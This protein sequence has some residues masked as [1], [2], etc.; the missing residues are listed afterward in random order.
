MLPV[1][2]VTGTRDVGTDPMPT[3]MQCVALPAPSETARSVSLVAVIGD[4]LP[5]LDSVFAQTPN[6]Y[7]VQRGWLEPSCPILREMSNWG[8]VSSH[9]PNITWLHWGEPTAATNRSR[10]REL[11]CTRVKGVMKRVKRDGGTMVW[12]SE[13]KHWPQLRN[14]PLVNSCPVYTC[15]LGVDRCMCFQVSIFW[16]HL[17]AVP[18]VCGR[19][20]AGEPLAPPER[21]EAYAAFCNHVF[22]WIQNQSHSFPATGTEGPSSIPKD[23]GASPSLGMLGATMDSTPAPVGAGVAI[24]PVGLTLDPNRETL[25]SNNHKR[26]TKREPPKGSPAR[27]NPKRTSDNPHAMPG[28]PTRYAGWS[29]PGTTPLDAKASDTTAAMVGMQPRSP[30][31]HGPT[32]SPTNP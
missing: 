11:L 24:T 30:W 21:Q 29:G 5:C 31:L 18:C 1:T 13:A 12:E 2:T 7:V 26:W 3:A 15:A 20:G 23:L 16:K 27:G 17:H 10:Q 6:V 19:Q 14:L 9:Q 4:E 8:V 25:A 32:S 28:A 22:N